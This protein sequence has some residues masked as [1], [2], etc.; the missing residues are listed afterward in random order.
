MQKQRPPDTG[1][2]E[3]LRSPQKDV[4]LEVLL[5]AGIQ[6]VGLG[7]ELHDDLFGNRHLPNHGVNRLIEI[8]KTA[9]YQHLVENI[10]GLNDVRVEA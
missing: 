5:E 7:R 4:G 6:H 10:A 9:G 3:C 2:A 8:H 1:I